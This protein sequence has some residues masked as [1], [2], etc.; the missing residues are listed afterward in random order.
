[1]R[2]VCDPRDDGVIAPLFRQSYILD[3]F[4]KLP[5]VEES[6][7]SPTDARLT[8]KRSMQFLDAMNT[9]WIIQVAATV[10]LD[11]RDNGRTEEAGWDFD[12]TMVGFHGEHQVRGNAKAPRAACK[13]QVSCSLSLDAAA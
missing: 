10:R 9:G 7:V 6:R 13:F 11:V 8:T 4:R 2:F 5:A 12:R 1:V 3:W